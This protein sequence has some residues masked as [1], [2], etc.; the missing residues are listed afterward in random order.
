MVYLF[1]MRGMTDRQQATDVLLSSAVLQTWGI[2]PLPAILR[3]AQGKPVFR[4]VPSLHFNL[5]H[6]G[7]FALCALSD[8]PVGVD[9]EAL[10]PRKPGLAEHIF[11]PAEQ[12]WYHCH[13]AGSDALL[14]L[15][16]RKEAWGKQRGTG[17]LFPVRTMT[18]PLPDE[19]ASSA[20]GAQVCSYSGPGWVAAV[21]G[22]AP[23]PADITWIA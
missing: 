5:S 14:T 13:G 22:K 17:L 4:D 6:S 18:P 19:A 7:S 8:A 21:F 3:L 2:T 12:Q 10:R 9:I 15:W 16:T 20:E 11:S 1:G 23:F